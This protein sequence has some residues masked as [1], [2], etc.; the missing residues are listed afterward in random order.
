MRGLLGTGGEG[1]SASGDGGA[2]GNRG[3]WGSASG[4]GGCW[5]QGVRGAAGDR[6][7][8]GSVSGEGSPLAG[9]MRGSEVVSGGMSACESSLCVSTD[10]ESLKN[11]AALQGIF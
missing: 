6:G 9:S 8:W 5:G 1:G 4:E 10:V 7:C 11:C 3:C 2:A